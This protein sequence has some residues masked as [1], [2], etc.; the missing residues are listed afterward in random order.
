V[1]VKISCSG[2]PLRGTK[3]SLSVVTAHREPL[4][5]LAS[6]PFDSGLWEHELQRAC[7]AS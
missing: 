6:V 7:T 4:E 1:S 3:L 2:D 5:L